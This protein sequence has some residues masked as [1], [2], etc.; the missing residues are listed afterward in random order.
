MQEKKMP[1]PFVEK[2]QSLQETKIRRGWF[3]KEGLGG[4][5]P[6]LPPNP[7]KGRFQRLFWNRDSVERNL[8]GVNKTGCPAG[9][10]DLRSGSWLRIALDYPNGLSRP[11]FRPGG[12]VHMAGPSQAIPG[13]SIRTKWT[14]SVSCWIIPRADQRPAAWG[15]ARRSLTCPVLPAGPW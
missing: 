9:F 1:R 5:I 7:H 3:S 15:I 12:R 8:K 13:R 10:L 2:E 4:P 11:T 14:D 6:T